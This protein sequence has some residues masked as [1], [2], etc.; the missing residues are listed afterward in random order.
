MSAFIAFDVLGPV[1]SMN[2]IV[3]IFAIDR[4][5]EIGIGIVSAGSS[6]FAGRRVGFTR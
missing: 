1:G 6:A 3:F 2:G 5:L 4:A